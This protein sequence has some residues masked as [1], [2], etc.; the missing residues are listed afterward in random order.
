MESRSQALKPFL[1][2]TENRHTNEETSWNNNIPNSCNIG[3]CRKAKWCWNFPSMFVSFLDICRFVSLRVVNPSLLL[4]CGHITV[5]PPRPHHCFFWQDNILT[6]IPVGPQQT[7]Y[8]L[9]TCSPFGTFKNHL[10]I[11]KNATVIDVVL[12]F[13]SNN[14]SPVPLLWHFC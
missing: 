2:Q 13:K 7:G 4:I 14:I 1:S 9:V 3:S 10:R 8:L 6:S 11:L 5:F 12:P